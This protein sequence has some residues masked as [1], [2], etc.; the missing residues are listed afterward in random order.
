MNI[1][2]V[3]T[4]YQANA[5]IEIIDQYQLESSSV[6]FISTIPL[7]VSVPGEYLFL[8]RI[9]GWKNVLNEVFSRR[10]SKSIDRLKNRTVSHVDLYIP[11]YLNM[12]TFTLVLA[13]RDKGNIYLIPDGV[14]NYYSKRF[15]LVD[16]L[17]QLKIKIVANLIGLKFTIFFKNFFNPFGE[18]TGIFSYAPEVTSDTCG[19][20]KPLRHASVRSGVLN[21]S[22]ILVV[23]TDLSLRSLPR[24]TASI[25]RLLK[26]KEFSCIRYRPHP[27]MDLNKDYAEFRSRFSEFEIILDSREFDPIQTVRA[28]DIGVVVSLEFST[29][30]CEVSHYFP[31]NVL[32]YLCCDKRLDKYFDELKP[33]FKHFGIEALGQPIRREIELQRSRSLKNRD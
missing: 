11:H 16:L 14:G 1:F 3:F 28:H 9:S 32:C 33:V 19:E 4:S 13:M 27:A 8:P 30:L 21:P 6:V 5:A 25:E 2:V 29:I 22:S 17:T 20:V 15:D 24:A 7:D 26:C 23:G 31:S 18:I 12:L 10:R